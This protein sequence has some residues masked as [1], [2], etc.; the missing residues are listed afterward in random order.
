MASGNPTHIKFYGNHK[1][2]VSILYFISILYTF[3]TNFFFTWQREKYIKVCRFPC[4]LSHTWQLL[5]LSHHLPTMHLST[6]VAV[7]FHE[8]DPFL[9]IPTHLH[10]FVGMATRSG[11]CLPPYFTTLMVLKSTFFSFSY[12]LMSNSHWQ[13]QRSLWHLLSRICQNR[14]DC[15]KIWPCF[16]IT[17]TPIRLAGN[18]GH[19]CHC[20]G[21]N[22]K[23]HSFFC[24][25]FFVSLLV[26]PYL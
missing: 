15:H 12:V 7:K 20:Q 10:S 21:N 24:C 11:G 4:L 17:S 14:E 18:I 23:F 6:F 26:F 19:S 22:L 16:W 8:H 9:L 25:F 3:I 5:N 13:C 1:K 2:L